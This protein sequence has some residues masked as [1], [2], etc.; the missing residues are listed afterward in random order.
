[1][2]LHYCDDEECPRLYQPHEHTSFA[3]AR[4]AVRQQLA[5][6]WPEGPADMLIDNLL[7][8]HARDLAQQQRDWM[9]SPFGRLALESSGADALPNLIDPEVGE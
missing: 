4:E 8:E 3:D 2:S 6:L 1:M 5:D 7:H 9:E